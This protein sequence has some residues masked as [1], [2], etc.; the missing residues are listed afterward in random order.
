MA[1]RGL[2]LQSTVPVPRLGVLSLR[3][4]SRSFASLVVARKWQ[5]AIPVL[6]CVFSAPL[7]SLR[8]RF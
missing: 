2:S 1:S 5:C 6:L 3:W 4:L 7:R 8:F